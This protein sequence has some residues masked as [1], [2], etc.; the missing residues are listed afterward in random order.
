[1]DRTTKNTKRKKD[2]I[3]FSVARGGEI[4]GEHTVSFIG[5]NDRV[6]LVHKANS[7]SIFVSGAISAAIFISKK[8]NG[9]FDIKDLLLKN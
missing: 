4:A 2:D 5:E 6:D 3:G 7:R 9:F 1:M 8:K